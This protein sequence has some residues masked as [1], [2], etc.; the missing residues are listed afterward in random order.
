MKTCMCIQRHG[1]V[2][3]SFS[4]DCAILTP[5]SW[6]LGSGHLIL[7]ASTCSHRAKEMG[8][9][10]HG[11]AKYNSR[12]LEKVSSLCFRV[13]RYIDPYAISSPP[14]AVTPRDSRSCFSGGSGSSHGARALFIAYID[15]HLISVHA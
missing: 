6:L 10:W 7:C 1:E 2:S 12:M 11:E 4:L 5:P 3:C 9:A 13:E 14:W 8:M 15:R